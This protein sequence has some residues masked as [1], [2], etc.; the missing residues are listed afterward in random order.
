V[1]LWPT[2]VLGP[3]IGQ[4]AQHADAVLGKEGQ[5]PIVEQVGGGNGRASG[6]ELRA[7][8]HH[9]AEG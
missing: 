5:H 7:R 1:A 9:T 8:L 6:V 3:A 2:A 4:D